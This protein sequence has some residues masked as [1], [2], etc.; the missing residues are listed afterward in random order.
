MRRTLPAVVL[1]VLASA[2][3][4][5]QPAVADPIW[6][7]TTWSAGGT[8][9]SGMTSQSA[10]VLPAL[11]APTAPVAAPA[12]EPVPIAASAGPA[13][14]AFAAAPIAPAP[15]PPVVFTPA[16]V[17]APVAPVAPVVSAPAAPAPAPA[18]A[19]VQNISLAT[20]IATPPYATSFPAAAP[21]A[22]AA[23]ATLSSGPPAT[24]YINMGS[25]P[26]AEANTLTGGNPQPWY[27]SP[28][29][30][31]FFNGTPTSTQQMSFQQ[32]I[33]QD[34][35]QT[36][37]LANIPITLTT[38]PGSPAL[39]TIS[40]V[41]GASDPSL[42][43]AVGVTDIGHNGF[44]FIDKLGGASNLTQFEWVVAHNIAHE[45]MH[46]IG[47]EH[48]DTTGLFLDSAQTQWSAMINPNT[49]F[50]PAAVQDIEGHLTASAA[51]TG[52]FDGQMLSGQPVPEPST[53]LIG[54]AGLGWLVQRR[55]KRTS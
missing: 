14:S 54:L 33:V 32:A 1:T 40:L 36:Y 8:S 3:L 25:G 27:E 47:G 4:C 31:K 53:L 24:A 11:S 29:V 20:G 38:N 45:L 30:A 15:A 49:T 42:P 12:V 52:N 48:H 22:P 34:V 37:H 41:S 13:V 44:S 10:F 51:Q 23:P 46:A 16:A 35:N 55:S 17:P 19:P 43:N 39:H 6:T 5:P 21:T 26:Y 18:P 7:W 28:V 9:S 2:I 50:S